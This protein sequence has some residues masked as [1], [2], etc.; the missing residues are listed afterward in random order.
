VVGLQ[1]FSEAAPGLG[2][3]GEPMLCE[4]VEHHAARSSREGV[5]WP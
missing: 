1:R 2:A 4:D 5:S 3:I